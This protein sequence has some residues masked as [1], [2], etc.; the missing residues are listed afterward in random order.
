MASPS[1]LEETPIVID[2]T[3]ENDENDDNDDLIILQPGMCY[4]EYKISLKENS[5][6]V[7]GFPNDNNARY[8]I[9]THTTLAHTVSSTHDPT[10]PSIE[11][12]IQK[13]RNSIV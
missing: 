12:F 5:G 2:D 6:D 10:T 3:D 9:I 7:I 13:L 4:F 8:T 11:Y 1:Q